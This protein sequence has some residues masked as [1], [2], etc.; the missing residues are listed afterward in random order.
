MAQHHSRLLSG[1]DLFSTRL[2]FA[3]HPQ[4]LKPL[5][6]LSGACKSES[7]EAEIKRCSFLIAIDFAL[8][9][10]LSLFVIPCKVGL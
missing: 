6:N 10:S 1:Q 9:L 7:R 2:V 8:F 5:S 4:L 3:Q